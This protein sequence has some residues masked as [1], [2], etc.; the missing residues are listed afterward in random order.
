MK[1][2]KF[3]EY[4]WLVFSDED[5]EGYKR[6]SKIKGVLLATFAVLLS[7]LIYATASYLDKQKT[8]SELTL[9]EDHDKD[10]ELSLTLEYLGQS[11]EEDV[12]LTVRPKKIDAQTAEILFDECEDWIRSV[13]AEGLIFPDSSPNGVLID[14]QNSDFS[15][16]G[17]K[18]RV[19]RIFIAQLAAGEFVRL[20]EF[21]VVLDP[22][23]ENYKDSLSV[24]AKA[25]QDSLSRSETGESLYLPDEEGGANLSWNLAKKQAPTAIIACGFFAGIAIYF[26]RRDTEKRQLKKRKTLF[27]NE[28]SNL[29]FQLVLYLNAGLT[30]DN[31]FSRIIR[32]NEENFNPLYR[33]LR[34]IKKSADAGNVPFVSQ[35][36]A[37]AQNAG[38]KS[39]LRLATLSYEHV[40]RGS[41]LTEKLDAETKRLQEERF[42]NAKTKIK[43]AETK[44]CFPLMMLLVVLVLIT[45]VPSFLSM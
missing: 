10:I 19:E 30:I 11:V 36:Y 42:L 1:K 34:D 12:L 6:S 25:L 41:D 32:Q 28:V 26:S 4:S 14:W 3:S 18:E 45:T 27:E 7:V 38:S 35:L 23:A 44:L 13:L 22:S 24:L 40:S 33:A 17:I 2:D 37:F 9:R 8:I 31:A 15:Y 5:Y 29:G 20:S 39:F 21:T 43:L 16:I